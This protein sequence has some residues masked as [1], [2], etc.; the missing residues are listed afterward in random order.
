MTKE[1]AI[2]LLTQ[3]PTAREI[4]SHLRTMRGYA[5]AYSDQGIFLHR[6]TRARSRKGVLEGRVLGTGEWTPIP[7]TARVALTWS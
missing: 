5:Y 4:N 3:Q 1:R 6:F 7:A 2:E